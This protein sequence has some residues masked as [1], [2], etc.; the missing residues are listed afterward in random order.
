MNI[1]M[2]NNDNSLHELFL[3]L[4]EKTELRNAFANNMSTD[5]KLLKALINKMLKSGVFLGN[6]LGKLAPIITKSAILF[7]K[8][9]LA[10]LGITAA[11][12]A[13]DGA[14]HKKMLGSG[15]NKNNTTFQIK[16]LMKLC[17]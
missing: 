7:A 8:N 14:I 17:K 16:I 10:P 9:I 11:A 5:I 3:T 6:L 13:I 1:N 2:F 15:I 4:R 12:S